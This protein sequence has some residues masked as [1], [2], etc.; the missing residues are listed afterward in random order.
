M[1]VKFYPKYCYDGGIGIP[2]P[3]VPCSEIVAL[4]SFKPLYIGVL[5]GLLEKRSRRSKI[6]GFMRCQRKDKV[7]LYLFLY[8]ID[9]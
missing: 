3:F 4:V 1:R 9:I 7:T 2:Y 5:H 6:R 8:S